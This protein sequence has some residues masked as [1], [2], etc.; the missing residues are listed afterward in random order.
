MTITSSTL[1]P[2]M[3]MFRVSTQAFQDEARSSCDC[4]GRPVHS[5]AGDL[6]IDGRPVAD[7]WYRWPDGHEGRFDL[8]I[9]PRGASGE[10]VEGMGVAV[11]SARIDAG[12]IIYSVLEPAA[13]PWSD[14]GAY[15]AMLSRAEALSTNWDP[16]LFDLVD[17]VAAKEPRLVVRI[18]ASSARPE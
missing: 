5:G 17:A 7:Y 9:C 15:G 3:E 1:G 14:F 8:A 2:M 10:H 6:L 12:N 13:A 4:C 16:G 18:L 11:L